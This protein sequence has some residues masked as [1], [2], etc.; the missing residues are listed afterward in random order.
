MR[1][2]PLFAFVLLVAASALPGASSAQTVAFAA[3]G[4]TNIRTGPGTQFPVIAAVHGGTEVDVLGCLSDRAWCE[5]QVYDVNGWMSSY[6]LEFVYAGNLRLVA[7]Y[8]AYFGAPIVSFDDWD[9]RRHRRDNN[10]TTECLAPEGFCPGDRPSQWDRYDQTEE[11]FQP[12]PRGSGQV[13]SGEAEIVVPPDELTARGS[14]GV[15][16]EC[17]APEGFC[18]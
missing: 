2:L 5:V 11:D 3:P 10:V 4:S 13:S 8:Y 7:E 16:T 9:D 17:L 14:G 6:R 1:Y 18:P 15:V 12:G